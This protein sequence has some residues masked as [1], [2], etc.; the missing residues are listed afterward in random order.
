MERSKV[1]FSFSD[2]E[3]IITYQSAYSKGTMIVDSNYYAK[4]MKLFERKM[5]DCVIL[6]MI[7]RRKDC[8]A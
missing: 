5:K 3:L 6:S 7:E 8:E 2:Y 1:R 4:Y